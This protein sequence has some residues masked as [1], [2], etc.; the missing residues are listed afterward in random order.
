MDILT[1]LVISSLNANVF[2]CLPLLREYLAR[3][4]HPFYLYWSSSV[5]CM[6]STC[7]VCTV[8]VLYVQ[9]IYCMYSTCTVC[10]VHVLYV[11]YMYCRWNVFLKNIF[12]ENWFWK[13]TL[14][15]ENIQFSKLLQNHAHEN[16]AVFAVNFHA[17]TSQFEFSC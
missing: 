8:H 4:I 11:Q 9:Y 6:Y 14:F 1:F 15:F 10:K 13:M 16:G 7:T 12:E 5:Y 3:S 2:F 17:E